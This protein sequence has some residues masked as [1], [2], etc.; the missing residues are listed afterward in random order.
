MF[1]RKNYKFWIISLNF[2]KNTTAKMKILCS[3]TDYIRY[4]YEVHYSNDASVKRSFLLQY[5]VY[6]IFALYIIFETW[7]AN[8]WIYC[9]YSF[10]E[11]KKMHPLYYY[12]FLDINQI[13]PYFLRS[14]V[15]VYIFFFYFN[16][17]ILFKYPLVSRDN[18]SDAYFLTFYAFMKFKD[19][20][21]YDS[22][23]I[24]IKSSQF[25]NWK[26]MDKLFITTFISDIITKYIVI[27]SSKYLY[28]M[29]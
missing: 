28:I 25:V 11:Y 22:S 10:E 29:I 3:N 12:F 8:W 2:L 14:I 17:F 7:Y 4:L 6:Q 16:H 19:C 21:K 27:G 26:T 13:N 5:M 15:P 1:Y 9:G 24:Y 23:Q 20:L 18:F